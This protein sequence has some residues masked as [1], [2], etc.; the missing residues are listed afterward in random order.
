M[1]VNFVGYFKPTQ[2]IWM[3]DLGQWDLVSPFPNSRRK[4]E[5]SGDTIPDEELFIHHEIIK[6]I[7]KAC[8]KKTKHVFLKGNHEER[9]SEACKLEPKWG[10][11]FCYHNMV[12]RWMNKLATKN[13]DYFELNVPYKPSPYI[14]YI[15]GIYWNMHHAKKHI[16]NL[17]KTTIYGHVHDVQRYYA[18]SPID[19]SDQMYAGS[20]GCL[21]SRNPEYKRNAPNRWANGFSITYIN[22]DGTFNEGVIHI[23]RDKF[24]FNNRVF[25]K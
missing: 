8:S 12:L 17:H 13:W 25:T 10:D 23:T 21:C 20:I 9:L 14:Q 11:M 5:L 2:V 4:A 22:E 3:G 16:E 15:H 6:P 18:C 24:V 1:F 7:A 19:N